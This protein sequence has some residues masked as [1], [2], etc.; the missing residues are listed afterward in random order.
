[1]R[2]LKKITAIALIAVLSVCLLTGCAEKMLSVAW[3]CPSPEGGMQGGP[4]GGPGGG[5]GG[6]PG[7]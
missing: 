7:F 2:Y 4:G 5:M 3:Q 1:M 6:G